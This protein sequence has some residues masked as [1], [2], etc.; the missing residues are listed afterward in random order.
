MFNRLLKDVVLSN[1]TGGTRVR[2]RV[3]V[4]PYAGREFD[5]DRVQE[6]NDGIISNCFHIIDNDIQTYFLEKDVAII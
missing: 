6:T 4:G 3:L 1:N 2:V 5:A